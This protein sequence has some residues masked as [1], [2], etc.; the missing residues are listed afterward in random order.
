V[1]L[2]NTT[3]IEIVDYWL[4][5]MIDSSYTS[6]FASS[7]EMPLVDQIAV[8]ANQ[9]DWQKQVHSSDSR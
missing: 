3:N 8:R 7:S 6:R 5:S 1:A 2:K 4:L 9:S